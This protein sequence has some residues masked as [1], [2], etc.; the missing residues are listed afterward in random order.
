MAK[1]EKPTATPRDFETVVDETNGLSFDVMR[2]K[3]SEEGDDPAALLLPGLTTD[4][5]N[6]CL[7]LMGGKAGT[8]TFFYKF[9][10]RTCQKYTNYTFS[11][12]FSWYF[13]K[14]FRHFV[15]GGSW[16]RYPKRPLTRLGSFV[17][18]NV[19]PYVKTF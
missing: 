7:Y 19:G 13:S 16:I 15:K 1:R 3:P 18:Q 8:G 6:S 5:E 17:C 4:T 12:F 9:H 2:V 14:K 11:I 10:W